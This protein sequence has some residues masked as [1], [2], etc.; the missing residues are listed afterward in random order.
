MSTHDELT[1]SASCG[2]FR[3]SQGCVRDHRVRRGPR[4]AECWV[5]CQLDGPGDAH[6]GPLNGSSG[7]FFLDEASALAAG[8][9]PC[10][11]CLP[12]RFEAF[13]AAWMEVLIGHAASALESGY[14]G[15]ASFLMA[16]P[17]LSAS[18]LDSILQGARINAD[19]QRRTT[20]ARLFEV[21][22][23]AFI[24]VPGRNGS[25]FL[26]LPEALLPW[27]PAGYGP[28]QPRSVP[29]PGVWVLTP[30]PILKLFARGFRPVLQAPTSERALCHTKTV[31]KLD[32][33]LEDQQ[34][35]QLLVR[36]YLERTIE[37]ERSTGAADAY[38]WLF[39][40]ALEERYATAVGLVH[41]NGGSEIERILFGALLLTFLEQDPLGL[42]IMGRVSNAPAAM[43][44]R[45]R[46]YGAGV[47]ENGRIVSAGSG[48]VARLTRADE[49]VHFILQ[50]GLPGFG[51]GKKRICPDA[52]AF[53]P[54]DPKFKLVIE[55]DGFQ[56]HGDKRSFSADRKR[57]RILMSAGYPV[58]RFSGSEIRE[59]PLR[60][61]RELFHALHQNRTSESAG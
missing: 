46:A 9:R 16:S 33:Q 2:M 11:Y 53:V 61:A 40:H 21:P 13:R 49:A 10:E 8:H 19:G 17:T 54:A 35:T 45:R 60:V 23:G 42:V 3:G 39:R 26:V 51:G 55:C 34:R 36:Q 5:Y 56:T 29:T 7:C 59:G 30:E 15:P 24:T 18:A 38:L 28:P 12:E 25:P 50:A 57:D 31:A 27:T 44:Q 41:A 20:L 22:D 43:E 37:Q 6:S 58:L 1:A 4:A 32:T 52:L 48:S 14:K 47:R